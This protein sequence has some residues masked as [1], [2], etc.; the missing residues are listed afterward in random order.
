[1]SRSSIL[2]GR[3]V[4]VVSVEDQV[5]KGLAKIKTEVAKL[6]YN[7]KR[8]GEQAM[9]GGFL[10]GLVTGGALKVFVDYDDQIRRL[11]AK[12]NIVGSR[13][14]EQEATM[15]SLEKR[16][17]SVGMAIGYTAG[18][19]AK[20][21]VELAAAGFGGSDIEGLLEGVLTLA[22]GT[23]FA[24][25]ESADLLANMI[26]NFKVF[27]GLT[28]TEQKIAATSKLVSQLVLATNM[29]TIEMED[30]RESFKYSG[31]T[32]KT[33]GEGIT[34]VLGVLVEMSESGL[35]ASLAGTSLNVEMQN[36]L[37]NSKKL[38]E[39]LPG[40]E[41][42]T[43]TGG[44]FMLFEN[45][46]QLFK[47]S[48]KLSRI[49]KVQLFQDIF[50]IRG[51]RA[52]T[53]QMDIEKIEENIETL[54]KALHEHILQTKQME[55]G[56]G[57]SL[58]RIKAAFHDNILTVI[59]SIEDELKAFFNSIPIAINAIGSALKANK[60][61]VLGIAFSP[62]ILGGAAIGLMS[63]AFAL[64]Q[65][66]KAAAL[67]RSGLGVIGKMAN[68][69]LSN[70]AK[71]G[72][73]SLTP[74]PK[75]LA[76]RKAL[77]SAQR[78]EAA[79]QKKL[80][81]SMSKAG[82]NITGPLTQKQQKKMAKI[83]ASRTVQNLADAKKAVAANTKTSKVAALIRNVR[84]GATAFAG[85][86]KSGAIGLSNMVKE[87]LFYRRK[88][89]EMKSAQK[90]DDILTRNAKKKVAGQATLNKL[91]GE[92]VRTQSK[93][94]NLKSGSKKEAYLLD[95]LAKENR[96]VLEQEHAYD[97]L[98]KTRKRIAAL[99]ALDYSTPKSAEYRKKNPLHVANMKR[100]DDKRNEELKR[101]REIEKR[102]VE[103]VNKPN[104]LAVIQK[105]LSKERLLLSNQEA[106]ANEK[107]RNIDKSRVN[108]AA[109][110]KMERDDL[111]EERL[112]R[113]VDRDD[114]IGGLKALKSRGIL[115]R[116]STGIKSMFSGGGKGLM[117]LFRGF[118]ILSKGISKFSLVVA[119][120]AL[121][122]NPF[123]LAL[124]ILLLFGHK[125]PLVVN[126]FKSLSEGIG[127]FVAEIAKIGPLLV[128]AIGLLQTVFEAFQ[129][130]A[131]GMG[132][133]G[134]VEG[135]KLVA[136]I[137]YNQIIAAWNAFLEKVAYIKLFLEKVFLGFATVFTAIIDS[138]ATTVGSIL[139]PIGSV[140]NLGSSVFAG[141]DGI[142]W[143]GL[144]KQL[145]LWADY[146]ITG[147]SKLWLYLKDILLETFMHITNNIIESIPLMSESAKGWRVMINTGLFQ[148][149]MRANK[150][151]MDE[152][153]A[154]RNERAKKIEELFAVSSD[155][156]A[157][158]Y[159]NKKNDANSKSNAASEALSLFAADLREVVREYKESV[160]IAELQLKQKDTPPEKRE[161]AAIQ[162]SISK[163]AKQASMMAASLVGSATSTRNNIADISRKTENALLSEIAKNT[164]DTKSAVETAG[165]F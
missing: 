117:A 122:M 63:I 74:L 36:M 140:F 159:A 75:E 95:E 6:S 55:S 87:Q 114:T 133:R 131:G 119:R 118:M 96:F 160:S 155:Q 162:Q 49:E 129:I 73:M 50:N 110:M 66:G 137:I 120:A 58:R 104:R 11:S 77:Q 46:Q 88:I 65:V 72:S 102:N 71:G 101:L 62:V 105:E 51:A 145:V 86:I 79:L 12:L 147:L 165:A 43:D 135:L 150:A 9:R 53:S 130:G 19:S 5:A 138:I 37:Q 94:T 141:G 143:N 84:S 28:S 56:I 54:G 152:M 127:A 139:G 10:G 158:F 69:S 107:L 26:K 85:G 17:R 161:P 4:I 106:K 153:D 25:D 8:L 82:L 34:T 146:L 93:I 68:A 2:A 61:A 33:L 22:K 70:L 44:N 47:M 23:G 67:A 98:Y 157:N 92:Y 123:T 42:L 13:T 116:I 108:V 112:F 113:K 142:D 144:G 134:L 109:K 14:K 124:N 57:G 156:A 32:A 136:S 20:A 39:A 18:E 78:K 111:D 100:M 27:D 83:Q 35:K 7:L 60:L 24:V 76:R 48:E 81:Q 128:P 164:A 40:F 3:A 38:K 121:S 91:N 52:V 148:E 103:L 89:K 21:S 125:I 97:K 126:T 99:E 151:A 41:I 45:L 90:L 31:G 163:A 29:G 80:D 115:S 154:G 149:Q 59:Y 64:N 15:A 1:M 16:I 30:L 132:M